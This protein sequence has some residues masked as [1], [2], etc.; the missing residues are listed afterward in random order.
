M[1]FGDRLRLLREQAGLSQD[2]LGKGLGARRKGA[3]PVDAGKQVVLGW[4]KNRHFPKADQLAGICEKLGCS[5]DYLLFGGQ[6]PLGPF[7]GIDPSKL[8][9]L[10]DVALTRLE[11]TIIGAAYTMFR[12]NIARPGYGAGK[13]PP[14]QSGA[15]PGPA[16]A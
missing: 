3:S 1:E 7:R 5:A 14:S 10:D 11:G 2:E 6:A 9:Q 13:L 12:I 4:E 8:T 16:A 15:N